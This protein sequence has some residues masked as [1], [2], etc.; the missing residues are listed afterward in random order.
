MDAAAGPIPFVPLTLKH[1]FA[2]LAAGS[3]PVH[4][5]ALYRRYTDWWLVDGELDLA[6]AAA[7][8]KRTEGM[9]VL[10]TDA[11]YRHRTAS[12]THRKAA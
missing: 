8:L 1:T 4:A 9:T 11:A 10:D 6:A 5:R 12:L 3:Q 7:T 2:A